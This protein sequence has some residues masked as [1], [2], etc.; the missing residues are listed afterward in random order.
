MSIDG[1]SGLH[2][3]VGSETQSQDNVHEAITR[4]MSEMPTQFT[5]EQKQKQKEN[6]D[7]IFEEVV[8]NIY[9]QQGG[10]ISQIEINSKVLQIPE[11]ENAHLADD[12][13]KG[14][15]PENVSTPRSLIQRTST[16][17]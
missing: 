9:I 12:L 13:F 3:N 7:K 16:N 5:I 2:F 6:L 14:L 10:A 1:I 4:L 17:I 8:E 15:A 11:E